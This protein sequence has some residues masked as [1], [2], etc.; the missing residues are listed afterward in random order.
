MNKT[1]R[2]IFILIL[3]IFFLIAFSESYFSLSIDNLAYVL[4]IGI[5]KSETNKMEVTFQFSTAAPSSESGSTEKAPVIIHT[6]D[7]SS[8]TNAFNLMNSYMGKEI[9]LSHCKVI[10]FSEEFAKSRYCN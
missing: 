8:L 7:S 5:D 2:N 4:A 3:I 10:V 9:N 1:F 6:V